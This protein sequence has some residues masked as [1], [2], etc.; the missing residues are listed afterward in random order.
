M[1]EHFGSDAHGMAVK[2]PEE[3]LEWLV[4]NHAVDAIRRHFPDVFE[5][6]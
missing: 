1:D 5:E 3:A 2:T 4:E 6:A